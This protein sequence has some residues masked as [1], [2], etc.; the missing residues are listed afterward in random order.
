MAFFRN[1][2]AKITPQ[3]LQTAVTVVRI[4]LTQILP[5]FFTTPQFALIFRLA[6]EAVEIFEDATTPG[7]EKQ[8]GALEY[9]KSATAAAGVSASTQLMNTAIELAVQR[10]KK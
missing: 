1:L 5:L 9:L 7:A 2:M 8:A 6:L 3:R 10:L 4:A